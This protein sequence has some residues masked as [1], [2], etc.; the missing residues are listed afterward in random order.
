MAGFVL[1]W[2]S[3]AQAVRRFDPI[4]GLSLPSWARTAGVAVMLAGGFLGATCG[5]IFGMVFALPRSPRLA[6]VLALFAFVPELR[7]ASFIFLPEVP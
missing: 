1:L 4:G 6:P 5:W 7:L 2:G 3:V